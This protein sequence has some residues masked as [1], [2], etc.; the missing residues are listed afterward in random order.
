MRKTRYTFRQLARITIEAETPLAIGSGDKDI[1]TDA[2]VVRDVNNM[3]F[4]PGTSITGVLRSAY[5]EKHE[6]KNTNKL[7]GFQKGDKGQGSELIITDAILI[8]KKGDALDGLQTIDINDPFY[9]NYYNLPI[10][11]HVS[12][13]DKGVAKNTGKFDEQVVYKGSRFVFEMELLS[14]DDR[15]ALMQTLL[16]MLKG[17]SFRLGGGTRSGFGKIKVIDILYRSLKLDDLA[18]LN[19]YLKKSSSLQDEW[20][21]YKPLEVETESDDNWT[22]YILTLTADDFF[23]FSSGFGDTDADITPVKEEVVTWVNGTPSFSEEQVLIPATS[24][25]GA[26]SHRVAYH[27]N[28]LKHLFADNVDAPC[29]VGDDNPAVK[30]L[31]G[32]TKDKDNVVRGNVL[33]RDV[34]SVHTNEK[35]SNHVAIDRFTRGSIDGALFTEK[36]IIG[37]GNTYKI[38]LQV[39]TCAFDYSEEGFPSDGAIQKALEQTLLDICNGLLPLGGGTNR[40]N[41]IFRGQLTKN[42]QAL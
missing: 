23:L 21:G 13:S 37:K 32:Y 35:I 18:D 4:I 38:E 27:W 25:K 40:G 19:L 39:K 24:V 33:M 14:G 16:G 42:G 26:I 22:T 6:E 29:L 5:S 7:F 28:K 11:Q 8:G 36:T 2:L 41:G 17:T 20:E 3:P 34:F 10:R 9:A 1:M 31:F 15:T 12:M 30:A